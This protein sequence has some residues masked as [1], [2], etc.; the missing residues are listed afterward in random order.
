MKKSNLF[1]E[2]FCLVILNILLFLSIEGQFKT[3]YYTIIS[4]L[5]SV[6]FFP[7]KL[8]FRAKIDNKFDLFSYFFTGIVIIFS[9][10]SFFIDHNNTLK[11]TL[12]VFQ[13]LN[14]MLLIKRISEKDALKLLIHVL[15]AVLIAGSYFL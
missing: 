9:S 11:L 3:F 13:L 1:F 2:I 5:I 8:I 12:F 6:Y 4:S 14:I 15:I 10:I 7:I